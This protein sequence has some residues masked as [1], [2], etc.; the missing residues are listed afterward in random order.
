MKLRNISILFIVGLLFFL[1]AGIIVSINPLGEPPTD[2]V[3]FRSYIEAFTIWQRIKSVDG[4]LIG[5]V[6][7][8]MISLYLRTKRLEREIEQLRGKILDAS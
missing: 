8:W 3:G 5:C 4:S 7:C 2:P 6:G 1:Q